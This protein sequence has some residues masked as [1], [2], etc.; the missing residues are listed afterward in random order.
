MQT[1]TH[2]IVRTGHY[3]LVDFSDEKKQ[4]IFRLSTRARR[5]LGWKFPNASFVVPL[6]TWVDEGDS[7]EDAIIAVVDA[8]SG[9]LYS[10]SV[11]TALKLHEYFTRDDVI[12]REQVMRT[13][14]TRR[15]LK[16][17]IAKR[18]Q[19]LE[20]TEAILRRE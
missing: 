15:R 8:Y 20:L 1:H 12:H 11:E 4:V 7:P 16:A 17:E 6:T 2:V 3:N 5:E 9:Y 18:V 19:L 10:S 14:A 13:F